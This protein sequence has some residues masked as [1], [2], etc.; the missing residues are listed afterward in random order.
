M[1][2]RPT[3]KVSIPLALKTLLISIMITWAATSVAQTV[4]YAGETGG[5]DKTNNQLL[6]TGKGFSKTSA[7]SAVGASGCGSAVTFGSGTVAN[8]ALTGGNIIFAAQVNTTATTPNST[9]FTVTFYLSTSIGSQTTYGPVYLSTG[10]SV[11]SGQA[12]DCKFDL[13]G[14][15]LPTPPFSYKL[16]VQ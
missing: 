10:A 3:A 12:I 14:S 4:S 13:G 2:T 15:S 6:A 9:C 8:T 5:L 1:R 16:A 7:A 11:T